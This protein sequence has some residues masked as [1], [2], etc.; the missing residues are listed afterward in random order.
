M[1]RNLSNSKYY[2]LLINRMNFNN[3]HHDSSKIYAG[4]DNHSDSVF[5]HGLSGFGITWSYLLVH[6]LLL[7]VGFLGFVLNT[8]CFITL[9]HK[10]SWLDISVIF[11][12]NLACSDIIMDMVCIYIVIY[13]LVHYKNYYECAFRLGL[14]TGIALNSALQLLGLTLDRYFKI[15]HPYKYV[16]IFSESSAKIYCALSWLISSVIS[17][18]PIFGLRRPPDCGLEYCSFFG[19]LTDEF[20]I[21]NIV[22]FY[23]TIVCMLFCYVR[24]MSVA[25]TQ[26]KE[27]AKKRITKHLWWKPTKTVMVLLM[28]YVLCW[29]PM[30]KY[31][32][33]VIFTQISAH[34]NFF[35][36][37]LP[38]YSRPNVFCYLF[39]SC[40]SWIM[41]TNLSS[42]ATIDLV[43]LV[44]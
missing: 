43:S 1:V 11:I 24:I 42:S 31:S 5:Y 22:C 33:L 13:N 6:L 18:L 12:T 38:M 20:L 17:L 10:E 28:F 41:V 16:R 4:S 15:L 26:N 44:L 14:V 37:F 34:W 8:F 2:D 3:C 19:V 29:L 21:V 9:R 36:L 30:S 23:S 35:S 27:C 25:W 40:T 7:L 39:K 32:N